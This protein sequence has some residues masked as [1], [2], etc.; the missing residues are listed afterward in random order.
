MISQKDYDIVHLE[1]LVKKV[2]NYGKLSE[3]YLKTATK[4]NKKMKKIHVWLGLVSSEAW[5]WSIQ[6]TPIYLFQNHIT[7]SFRQH[8]LQTCQNGF[9]D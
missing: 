7:S 1:S 5:T 8:M 6:H 3:T 2:Q 4:T 9:V